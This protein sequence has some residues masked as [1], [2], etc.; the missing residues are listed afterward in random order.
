MTLKLSCPSC[1]LSIA[2][3]FQVWCER[4]RWL[5]CRQPWWW[6]WPAGTRKQ[7]NGLPFQPWAKKPAG[8]CPLEHHDPEI[9]N[10]TVKND[11]H[12]QFI[13]TGGIGIVV[14]NWVHPPAGLAPPSWQQLQWTQCSPLE[15]RGPHWCLSVDEDNGAKIVHRQDVGSR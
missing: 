13:C 4:D 14:N 1:F 6:F 7:Q 11:L 10:T 15:S 5:S 8:S 3:L 2:H 12:V 9:E